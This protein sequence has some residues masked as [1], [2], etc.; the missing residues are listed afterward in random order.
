M[1][2]RYFKWIH[3]WHH[4]II[5]PEPQHSIYCSPIEHMLVNMIPI[6]VPGSIL[7]INAWILLVWE[8]IAAINTMNGH[9][10]KYIRF[11]PIGDKHLLH[12]TLSTV[13]YG[14]L[15]FFDKVN[16][17]FMTIDKLSDNGMAVQL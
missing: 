9:S 3:K 2:T 11:L 14:V 7:N 1:H 8:I 13:N 5:Y 15:S 6:L 17:S 10:N 4:E 16:G 12:H